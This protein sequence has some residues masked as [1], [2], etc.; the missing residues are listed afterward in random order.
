[1]V[2]VDDGVQFDE[3]GFPGLRERL[4]GVAEDV[5]VPDGVVETMQGVY[6]DLKPHL[7]VF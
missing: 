3:V 2:L 4:V 1:M 5:L 6:Q 7:L